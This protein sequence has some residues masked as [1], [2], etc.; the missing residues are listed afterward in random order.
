MLPTNTPPRGQL[1]HTGTGGL[2]LAYDAAG[3]LSQLHRG[4]YGDAEQDMES[5]PLGLYNSQTATGATE[6][7]YPIKGLP[8]RFFGEFP[9]RANPGSMKAFKP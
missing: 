7:I 1:T 5:M 6:V 8:Y 9:D 3:R 4:A 2:A